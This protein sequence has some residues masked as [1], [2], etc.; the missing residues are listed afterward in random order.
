MTKANF[1]AVP[2]EVM[3]GLYKSDLSG[4]EL[5][6]LLFIIRRTIGFHKASFTMSSDAI[7]KETGASSR[8]V[9]RAMLKLVELGFVKLSHD[10]VSHSITF[11]DMP[12]DKSDTPA[13]DKNDTS[14]CDKSDTQPVTSMSHIPYY[15]ENIKENDKERE[16]KTSSPTYEELVDEYG[17]D[18]VDL[19]VS[20]VREWH[21][22]NNK[23]LRDIYSVVRKWL[24]EDG[25]TID[26]SDEYY[27]NKYDFVYNAF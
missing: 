5:R 16:R 7:A 19:Y 24:V 17:S 26:K 8:S 22:R 13:C 11:L 2:N 9:K 18:N 20:K 23:P 4:S 10:D 1:T 25:V 27:H 12:C 6:I 15:K 14:A 3:E 21:E